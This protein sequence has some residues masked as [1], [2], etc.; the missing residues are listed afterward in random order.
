MPKSLITDAQK[1]MVVIRYRDSKWTMRKIAQSL[2]TSPRTINRILV[3]KGVLDRPVIRARQIEKVLKYYGLEN[4]DQLHLALE[5]LKED[6]IIVVRDFMVNM[7]VE[8]YAVLL[9][10]IIH[11]REAKRHNSSVANVMKQLANKAG[12][13]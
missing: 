11:L 3:E 4:P 7:P 1:D 10:D 5:Y 9:K 13:S 8:A 2:N 12:G 6:K